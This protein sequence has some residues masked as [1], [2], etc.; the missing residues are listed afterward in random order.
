[1]QPL[2]LHTFLVAGRCDGSAIAAANTRSHLV[3]SFYEIYIT[4]HGS[5]NIK[6]R[7]NFGFLLSVETAEDGAS[8]ALLTQKPTKVDTDKVETRHQ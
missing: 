7:N 4:M 3:G 6:S 2:V 5:L 1:M 8:S